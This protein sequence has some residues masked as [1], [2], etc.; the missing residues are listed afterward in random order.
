ML[1]DI[2]LELDSI[3]PQIAARMTGP[4][5]S[6]QRYEKKRKQMMV[7][8]LERIRSSSRLSRDVFEIVNKGLEGSGG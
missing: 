5:I 2:V 6:W 1:V 7:A 8:S 3:N 4:L